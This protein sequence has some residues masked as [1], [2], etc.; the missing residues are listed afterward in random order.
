MDDLRA[1]KFVNGR[2]LNVDNLLNNYFNSFLDNDV[3]WN[4]DEFLYNYLYYFLHYNED[5]YR[6][7]DNLF[8]FNFNYLFDLNF[9]DLFKGPDGLT[10]WRRRFGAEHEFRPSLLAALVLS[11]T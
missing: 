7:F 4:F 1:L 8:N 2:S 6:N 5:L 11:P 3:H 10:Q 9:N